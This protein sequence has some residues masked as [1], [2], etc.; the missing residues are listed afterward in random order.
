MKTWTK[1]LV[2]GLQ[3]ATNYAQAKVHLLKITIGH[4]GRRDRILTLHAF[5][6][7]EVW[8]MI[9]ETSPSIQERNESSNTVN[10]NRVYFDS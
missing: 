4:M 9:L 1:P 7:E 10:R 2:S 3:P 5:V 8:H 6:H